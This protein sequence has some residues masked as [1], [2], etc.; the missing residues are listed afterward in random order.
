MTIMDTSAEDVE[1]TMQ[2]SKELQEK[3]DALAQEY[4]AGKQEFEKLAAACQ[5]EFDRLS[6][7]A[8][9]P[10]ATSQM[11]Q[12]SYDAAMEF[13][14]DCKELEKFLADTANR[15]ATAAAPGPA[16][17]RSVRGMRI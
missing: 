11:G 6:G 16:A 9:T 15:P 12:Q 13:L 8:D 10:R 5:S 2:L 3:A 14:A 7:L 17:R 4:E 1:R